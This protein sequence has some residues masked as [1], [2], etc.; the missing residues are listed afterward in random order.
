MFRDILKLIKVIV[1]A[2]LG[3]VDRRKQS[4]KRTIAILVLCCV[5]LGATSQLCGA[6]SWFDTTQ[7]KTKNMLY[8]SL[9][10]TGTTT[11]LS[12][13][14][15]IY[16]HGP[17]GLET[18]L[19]KVYN[20]D[21]F[22]SVFPA[23]LHLDPLYWNK[24][25][26]KN[27]DG[28]ILWQPYIYAGGSVWASDLEETYEKI[29]EIGAGIAVN[30]PLFPVDVGYVYRKSSWKNEPE[31]LIE[32]NL[33]I[34]GVFGTPSDFIERSKFRP[35][36]RSTFK[37]PQLLKAGEDVQLTIKVS[38]AKYEYEKSAKDISLN[39]FT[40]SNY[41]TILSQPKKIDK[42]KPEESTNITVPIRIDHEAHGDIRFW[43]S[44]SDKDGN[45]FRNQVTT[46]IEVIPPKLTIASIKAID[47]HSSTSD[48]ELSANDKGD[49]T[50]TV[51]NDGEGIS[52]G[53]KVHVS[54][55][56][57]EVSAQSPIK[58][59]KLPSGE[60]RTIKVP[61]ATKRDA[62]SGSVQFSIAAVDD[63]NFK[64]VA[65]T[66]EIPVAQGKPEIVLSTPT[67][68]EVSR[69]FNNRALDAG[70]R[71][72]L[73]FTV[74]NQG[75]G[76]AFDAKLSVSV[77]N[78]D[79]S[80]DLPKDGQL[81]NLYVGEPKNVSIPIKTNFNAK[82]GQATFR[83]EVKDRSF[84]GDRK[85]LRLD[86]VGL[87]KPELEFISLQIDDSTGGARFGDSN[88]IPSNEEIVEIAAI[89]RNSGVGDALG[90]MLEL[91]EINDGLDV[92]VEKVE[93]G[94][95]KPNQNVE[96]RLRFS[97]PRTYKAEQLD[98]TLKVS[99]KRGSSVAVN[100]ISK[101]ILM[102]QNIPILECELT[103]KSML[104]NG[105]AAD[106]SATVK[107]TGKLAANGVKLQLSA[108]GASILP[109]FIEIGSLSNAKSFPQQFSVALPRD[110]NRKNVEVTATLTQEFFSKAIVTKSFPVKLRSPKFD[111]FVSDNRNGSVKLGDT[112]T[113]SVRISNKGDMDAL[114]TTIQTSTINPDAQI[115]PASYPL[116]AIG[117]GK[118][119]ETVNF[120]I[121]VSRKGSAGELPITLTVSE[122]DFG[123]TTHSVSYTIISAAPELSLT[124]EITESAGQNDNGAIEQ[125]GKADLTVTITNSGDMPANGVKV[126]ASTEVH[127][128]YI[129]T[130]QGYLKRRTQN[131]GSIKEATSETATF[132]FDVRHGVE[133]PI[134][135]K[136]IPFPIK[137]VVEQDDFGGIQQLLNSKIYEAGVEQVVIEQ[138]RAKQER[139]KLEMPPDDRSPTIKFS[140]IT[141]GRTFYSSPIKFSASVA[142]DRQLKRVYVQQEVNG[143]KVYDSGQITD[144]LVN[145][146][147]IPIYL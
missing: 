135:R 125:G 128:V 86:L 117:V 39:I 51:R 49:L 104:K 109:A 31:H 133:I 145:F 48:G 46:M 40:D 88:G 42:L 11:P 103:P 114:D 99:D 3:Q 75:K 132:T 108:P 27:S 29:F 10:G 57:Q 41:V 146:E 89:I 105:T 6:Y 63:Y 79:L 18:A 32:L 113:M 73:E 112:L 71:G 4:M 130:V 17:I 92:Q 126:T 124:A 72:V 43:L 131:I 7:C 65:K 53:L 38:N 142:D 95:I 30:I 25:V 60:S 119:A 76:T 144:I 24:T 62:G 111:L 74:E 139:E 37:L 66:P 70:E 67:F 78:S 59:G 97:V 147:T 123:Q 96:G 19:V 137:I 44:V 77:D 9:A 8:F 35:R 87:R 47:L 122:K 115:T 36:L 14:R 81:G 82:D 84:N 98:F 23:Y 5:M 69:Y 20:W 52:H 143:P 140:G 121:N 134:G 94:T 55:D 33:G 16:T 129:E 64:A 22:F 58:V 50:V 12:V 136:S 91:T 120:S 93:L 56:N 21:S 45:T 107:N 102:S 28:M 54:S 1:L 61:I 2:M 127:G 15:I 68:S 83:I 90:V 138:D 80:F 100:S 13:F 118:S 26:V 110:F 85:Y 141:D 116:G 101:S 34:I 106:F